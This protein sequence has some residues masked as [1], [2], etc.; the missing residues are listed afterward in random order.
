MFDMLFKRHFVVFFSLFTLSCA[1]SSKETVIVYSPHGKEML[2]YYEQAFEKENPTIDVRWL[3]MGAQTAF[4]RLRTEKSNPQSSLWWGGPSD[5]FEQ[6]EALGLLEP[7]KPSWH[8]KVDAR[9][10]SPSDFW[11]ASFLTPECIMFNSELLD[12]NTAPQDWDDMLSDQWKGKIVI[13]DPI[14]SGTM[15]T[16]FAALVAKEL[17]RTGSLDSG[18]YY[19]AR[20][21][22]NTKSYAA[23]PSQLYLKLSRGEA[24]VTLWNLTDALLQ[25]KQNQF[26]FGFVIPKSG[27]VVAVE[28]IALV[29]GGKNLGS[30]KKF[31]EFV[32]SKESLNEQAEKF[33]RLPVRT[34]VEVQSDWAKEARYILLNIDHNLASKMQ[35]EWMARWTE[36]IKNQ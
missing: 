17:A 12:K 9:Y 8:E 15:R 32:T 34:D 24:L 27:T 35:S 23:D 29:K 10:H 3:D 16:I 2:G 13:R 18:F 20:L 22:R 1:Q 11:Y 36:S 33:Y 31:Y 19:L 4:D 14:Q 28:G 6:A 25:A 21:H 5:L 7:Y 30:A 26:P